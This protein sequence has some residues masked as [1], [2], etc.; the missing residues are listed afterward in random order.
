MN[1][2]Q[3][4]VLTALNSSCVVWT[5]KQAFPESQYTFLIFIT[6]YRINW[7]ISVSSFVQLQ[8]ISR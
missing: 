5:L 6:F 2:T 8:N 1:I 4:A 7:G 3:V